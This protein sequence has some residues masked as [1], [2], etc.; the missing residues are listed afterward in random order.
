MM[1]YIEIGQ[2]RFK[3]VARDGEPMS[4]K[5]DQIEKLWETGI[6]SFHA[7]ASKMNLDTRTVKN[8]LKAKSMI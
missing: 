1:P 5:I 4:E 8:V 2:Y 7:I 6:Y 3:G